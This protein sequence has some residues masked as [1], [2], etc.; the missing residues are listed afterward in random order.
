V[1]LLALL[2]GALL[3][4][5][6]GWIFIVALRG[7]VVVARIIRQP[8]IAVARIAAGPVEIAGTLVPSGDPIMSAS[9]SNCVAVTTK[10]TC[11]R[12]R[13]KGSTTV[14]TPTSI[15]YADA[16]LTDA[17]GSCRIDLACAAI[18]G[19]RRKSDFVE[20]Y[21]VPHE[22]WLLEMLAPEADNFEIE[23]TIIP[24]GVQVLVSGEAAETD[25]RVDGSAYRENA[26][27]WKVSGRPDR[28]LVASVG[29]QARLLFVTALPALLLLSIAGYLAFVA[30]VSIAAMT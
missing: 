16:R 2:V 13:G 21:D 8:T 30:L 23:E 5:T 14:S 20:R 3:L 12:G 4:I 6:A 17:T 10:V 26:V 19:Q 7:L 18:V 1:S 11:R 28:L 27:E 24:V 29:G 22:P 15:R 25:V 9:G